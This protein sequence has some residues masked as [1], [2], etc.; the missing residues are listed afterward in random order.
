L[1]DDGW[2]NIPG[3]GSVV[4]TQINFLLTAARGNQEGDYWRNTYEWTGCSPHA[5]SGWD[6]NLYRAQP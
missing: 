2:T 6:E 5:Q 3:V 4:P 1:I